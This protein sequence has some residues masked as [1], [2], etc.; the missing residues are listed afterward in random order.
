[1]TDN[2]EKKAEWVADEN[3]VY[4]LMCDGKEVV[5]IKPEDVE[6]TIQEKRL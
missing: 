3:G 1:M 6:E 5:P 4:R 2:K